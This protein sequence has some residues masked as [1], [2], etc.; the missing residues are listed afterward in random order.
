MSDDD[1]ANS[2]YIDFPIIQR[3]PI[4]I[5]ISDEDDQQPQIAI[6]VNNEKEDQSKFRVK[7]INGCFQMNDEVYF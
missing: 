4:I 6:R 2:N 1:T 5:E 7:R 3:E